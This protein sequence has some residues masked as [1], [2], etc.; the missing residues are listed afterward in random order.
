M[1]DELLPK[2]TRWGRHP[3]LYELQHFEVEAWGE[4][5]VVCKTADGKWKAGVWKTIEEIKEA[6]LQ[7]SASH[8]EKHAQP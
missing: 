7:R 2:L 5:I 1:N 8:Q 4:R 6:H 3:D